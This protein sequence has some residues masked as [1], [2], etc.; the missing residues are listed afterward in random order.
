MSGNLAL[1]LHDTVTQALE[2]AHHCCSPLPLFFCILTDTCN[3][4]HIKMD[5]ATKFHAH[6]LTFTLSP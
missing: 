3:H 2:E 5:S 4:E 6:R 1:K